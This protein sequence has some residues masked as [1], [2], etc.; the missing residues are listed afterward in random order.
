[1]P[2]LAA[3]L[4]SFCVAGSAAGKT[5]EEDVQHYLGLLG[6]PNPRTQ[7]T[8]FEALSAMGLSDPR[9]FDEVEKRMLAD[10]EGARQ[11]RWSRQRV[12]WYFRALGFSG[13]DKYTA[14]LSR[15]TGDPTY[16][17]YAIVALRELPQYAKWNPIISSRTSFDPARSD[18]ANRFVNMLRSDDPLLHRVAAKRIVQTHETTPAVAELLAE[19]VRASYMNATAYDTEALETVGWLLNALGPSRDRYARLLREVSTNAPADKLRARALT[20]LEG[21]R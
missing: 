20:V 6:E 1:M 17:N 3:L 14:T 5:I 9:L 11:E 4:F 8:E 10:L 21:R 19:R 18:N 13:Q 2:R 12:A 16:R 7:S 15:F